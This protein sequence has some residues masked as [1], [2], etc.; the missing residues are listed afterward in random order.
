MRLL[1]LG[2]NDPR[3]KSSN[4]YSEGV[5]TRRQHLQVFL[6]CTPAE[7]Q[8]RISKLYKHTHVKFQLELYRAGY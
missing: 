3:F 4:I 6:K 5:V 7:F 2:K 1:P 8:I